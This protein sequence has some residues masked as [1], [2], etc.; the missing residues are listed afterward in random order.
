MTRLF[1]L[2]LFVFSSVPAFAMPQFLQLYRSD[3]FRNPAVDGCN[4]CHM[5]PQGGDARNPFGQA[6]ESAGETITPL[7]RAQF[8]DRFAYPTSRVTDALT[9]HFSDPDKKQM[10]IEASG[11]KHVADI[12]RKAVDGRDASSPNA[13]ASALAQ[14]STPVPSEVRVDPFSREGAFFGSNIV[15]LPDG[16]PQRAGGVDFFVGHRFTQDVNDAKL[17]G[18][19]GFDSPAVIAFGL[20]VGITDRVS[21]NVLRSNLDKT[22]SLGT[23]FQVS[24]QN[25]EVPLTLQIRAGVDGKRNFGLYRPKNRPFDDRQ[26]SP[27]IQI[28]GT[29]TF[30]DRVSFTLVPMYAFNTRDESRGDDLPG[31]SFGGN[32]NDT[33]A[34]GI[35]TGVRILKSTSL[36]GEY[37]PRLG[38]FKGDLDRPGVSIGL[39]KAT[40]RHTFEILISRQRPLTPAQDSFQGVDRFAIGFNIYRKLR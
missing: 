25:A 11:M 22:I 1:V 2:I 37:I 18:L 21:V 20:R 9:I 36:V 27:Y 39:Q 32:H 40:F 24:R 16:K 3:P 19:L 30:K 7:L 5:S 14:S 34:L 17:T 29:R 8:P 35:G 4:T 12:D 33:I 31:L 15:N 23:A 6:F 28:V 13:P 26:Y 10:V 38:G